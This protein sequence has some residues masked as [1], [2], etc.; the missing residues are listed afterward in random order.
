MTELEILALKI[1]VINKSLGV[2][3]VCHA[4]A[5]APSSAVIM[6]G[7][8]NRLFEPKILLGEFPIVA[9]NDEQHRN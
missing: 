9:Q 2:K 7:F 3:V 4:P 8:D 5:T 6:G 1:I